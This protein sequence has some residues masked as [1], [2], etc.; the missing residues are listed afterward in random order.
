[1]HGLK[2]PLSSLSQFVSSR[3]DGR[4]EPDEGDW[5][6]ALTAAYRMQTLMGQTLEVLGDVQGAPAY[7]M[8]VDELLEEMRVRVA[9]S[10]GRRN[11]ALSIEAEGRCTLSSHTANLAGLILTNLLEN[12]IEVTPSGGAVSLR[13]ERGEGSIRFR[14][15]DGGGGFPD[16]LRDQLFLPCKSTRD[17]GSG[18]GLAISK[19]IADHLGARLALEESTPTGCAFLLELPLSVC[20]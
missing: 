8:A 11:I 2:N 7:E 16:P 1:M 13:A 18:I 15:R 14:V 20:Q 6:D 10:A 5:Q 17:G 3:R 9:D 4:M 12:A 19:L